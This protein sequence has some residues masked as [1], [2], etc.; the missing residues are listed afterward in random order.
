MPGRCIWCI[1]FVKRLHGRFYPRNIFFF[2]LAVYIFMYTPWLLVHTNYK[3]L[4]TVVLFC[5]SLVFFCFNDPC[6]Y[7]RRG[8]HVL[9][10]VTRMLV[11]RLYLSRGWKPHPSSLQ[12]TAAHHDNSRQERSK[13]DKCCT[14]N[15]KCFSWRTSIHWIGTFHASRFRPT[16]AKIMLAIGIATARAHFFSSSI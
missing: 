5:S 9:W 12:P 15:N 7:G 4:C 6:R 11:V 14:D 16:I 8:T 13:E 2:D 3:I 1:W 10:P